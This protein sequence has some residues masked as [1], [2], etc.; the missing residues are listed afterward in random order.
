MTG[1]LYWQWYWCIVRR[2]TECDTAMS[3]RSVTVSMP[4]CLHRRQ[5]R[6]YCNLSVGSAQPITARAHGSYYRYSTKATKMKAS[7]AASETLEVICVSSCISPR[8]H[9]VRLIYCDRL[10]SC[11]TLII[12]IIIIIIT[13]V[14]EVHNTKASQHDM[15][16]KSWTTTLK[17]NKRKIHRLKTTRTDSRNTH[18][19]VITIIH[20]FIH[21]F[22]LF[23]IRQHGP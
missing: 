11:M 4:L 20:S 8:R 19:Y 13:I 17:H 23:C 3:I 1:Q 15:T 7:T 5:S 6:I 10:K 22:I 16:T 18:I 9:W 2:S 12:I 14:H 21:S